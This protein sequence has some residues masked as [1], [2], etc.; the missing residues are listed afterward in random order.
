MISLFL[1][2]KNYFNIS[3]IKTNIIISAIK[4]GVMHKHTSTSGGFLV[5]FYHSYQ[6]DT[7]IEQLCLLFVKK[8]RETFLCFFKI[9]KIQ[10][11]IFQ[12]KN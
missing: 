6:G 10:F 4:R 2:F 8:N 1:N 9:K 3:K 12:T 7:I 5:V 11:A